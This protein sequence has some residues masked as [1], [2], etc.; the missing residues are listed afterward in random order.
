MKKLLLLFIITSNIGFSQFEFEIPVGYYSHKTTE[1]GV[2]VSISKVSKGIITSS[3][4]IKENDDWSFSMFTNQDYIDNQISST[5]IE[6]LFTGYFNEFKLLLKKEL[7]FNSIGDTFM[8]QFSYEEN[9]N[10]LIKTLIQFIK[11]NKL[12]SCS[13][14]TIANSFRLNFN[15]YLTIIESIR[16]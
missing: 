4:E 6:S 9:G 3:F 16:F 8:I 11:N 2:I 15:D 13:G 10:K 5:E 14:T 7:Y 1:K 12:Y